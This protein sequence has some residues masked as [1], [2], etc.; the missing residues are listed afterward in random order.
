MSVTQVT[1]HHLRSLSITGHTPGAAK[2]RMSII[3]ARPDTPELKRGRTLESYN[4]RAINPVLGAVFDEALQLK[5]VLSW[6]QDKRDALLRDLAITSASVALPGCADRAVSRRGVVAIKGQQALTND[7]L[8]TLAGEFGRLTGA[9]AESTV[10][11]HP[12]SQKVRRSRR[13]SVADRAQ[14]FNEDGSPK[15]RGEMI[16]ND[17]DSRGARVSGRDDTPSQFASAGW[18]T[19][20]RVLAAPC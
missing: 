14:D 13:G 5:D 6:P 11:V 3:E 7:D 16:T 19:C 18:H 9:P 4:R 20:V 17:R 10:H 1:T 12:L 2:K 15:K 8:T